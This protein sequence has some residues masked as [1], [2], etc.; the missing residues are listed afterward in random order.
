MAKMK[1]DGDMLSRLDAEE[2]TMRKEDVPEGYFKVELSTKGLLGAPSEF[3][4]RNFDTTDLMNL[5]LT[6]SS[7]IQEKV[8]KMLDSLIL[9]EGVSVLDF[10]EKEVIETL[11]RLYQYFYS[12]MINEA[13]FPWNEDDLK[14]L[15][16]ILKDEQEYIARVQDLK[17]RRWIPRTDI[18][19]SKVDPFEIDEAKFKSKII[20]S[21]KDKSFSVGFTFPRYGDVLVLKNFIKKEFAEED[22]RYA[23]LLETLKF[24]RDAEDRI[25]RG[26]DI[27][28]NRLPN[29]PQ[30]EKDKLKAYEEKKTEFSVR[31]IKALHLYIYKGEDVSHLPLS[32]RMQMASDAR[33]DYKMMKKVNEYYSEMKIGLDDSQVKMF[34][35]ITGKSE[36]RRYSFRILDLLQT[37]KLYDSDDFD[38]S[39]ES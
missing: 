32:Q 3:H 36:K 1:E 12:D 30:A 11:V 38:I 26:E 7:D 33:I 18:D 13:E 6:D 9:E 23:S 4:M 29:I 14:A 24:R 2:E 27:P 15:R 21:S 20:L 35:P 16:E 10:H 8:A 34:N 37:I 22:K 25:R 31:A 28:L 19:L 17:L 5:A 39:F